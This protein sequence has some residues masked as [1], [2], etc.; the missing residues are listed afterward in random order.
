LKSEKYDF[1]ISQENFIASTGE[2]IP[3]V[4]IVISR[5]S[6]FVISQNLVFSIS[7]FT[8]TTGEKFASISKRF[9]SSSSFFKSSTLT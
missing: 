3:F 4:V 6:R 8:F 2:I 9:T 5:A 1:N 7:Y